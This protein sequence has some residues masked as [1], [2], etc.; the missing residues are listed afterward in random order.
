M[1]GGG[2]LAAAA[3]LVVGDALAG[4][5][6]DVGFRVISRDAAAHA[7]L[8]LAGHGQ[9]GLLDVASVLGRGLEEGNA[10]GIGEF[11]TRSASCGGATRGYASS[12]YLGHCVLNHLLVGH[13]AL[14]SHEELVNALGG[15]SVDLLQ[16]LLDVVEAVHVGDVVDDAD[17]VG[18]P[19]VGRGDGA[20]PLL[21]GRVPLCSSQPTA[22][23]SLCCLATSA[24]LWSWGV[25]AYDLQLHRLAIELDRP[26]FLRRSASA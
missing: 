18:A 6:V 17:A 16:P 22:L 23:P 15:V 13:I 9:E 2:R 5:D 12:R 20:E 25:E 3:L 8:D 1:S 4:S 24:G 19:V 11:L 26:D 14:V 10:E 21:A 7:L